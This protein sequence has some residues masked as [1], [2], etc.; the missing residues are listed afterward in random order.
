M[1]TALPSAELDQ[2]CSALAS[3]GD[4]GPAIEAL[5]KSVVGYAGRPETLDLLWDCDSVIA[6]IE[7]LQ[8]SD[9]RQNRERLIEAIRAEM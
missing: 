8:E 3:N 7:I 2:L 6:A 4:A 1:L 5:F 9:T